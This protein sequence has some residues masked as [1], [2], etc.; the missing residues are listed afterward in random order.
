VSKGPRFLLVFIFMDIITVTLYMISANLDPRLFRFFDL[1]EEANFPAWYASSKFLLCAFMAG[2]LL[3]RTNYKD[4][5]FFPLSA[6][7]CVMVLLSM[8]EAAMVHE[9]FAAVL[10]GVLLVD[11]TKTAL[12]ATGLWVVM[13]GF[14]A[15][16]IFYLCLKALRRSRHALSKVVPKM[17]IGFAVLLSG[18][19]GAEVL[20]NFSGNIS[21]TFSA[22]V[23]LEEFLELIGASILLSACIDMTA[24]SSDRAVT[25]TVQ[26]YASI[27]ERNHRFSD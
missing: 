10:E 6:F 18:A 1:D 13:I 7:V 8:D 23:L 15:A 17:A 26:G 25:E 9:R 27:M 5:L 2:I 14:P 20:T 22:Q 3:I 4:R 19:I 11:R 12:P 24:Q 16:Y 21:G